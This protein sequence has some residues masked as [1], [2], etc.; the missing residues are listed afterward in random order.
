MKSDVEQ[1]KRKK[2]EEYYNWMIRV[3]RGAKEKYW[4]C[5]FK[6]FTTRALYRISD[7]AYN[8]IN[9]KNVTTTVVVL[10]SFPDVAWPDH[11][12]RFTHPNVRKQIRSTISHLSDPGLSP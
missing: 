7:F 6:S 8:S 10:T 12:D 3:T 2:D 11:R 4:Q 9:P 1:P 5:G